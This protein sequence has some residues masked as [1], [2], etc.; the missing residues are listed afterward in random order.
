VEWRTLWLWIESGAPY[1]G[2]YAALRNEHEQ[3]LANRAVGRVFAEG[4]SV[5][6]RRCFKCHN[7]V[8]SRVGEE[9][10]LPFDYEARRKSKGVVARPTAVYERLVLEDDPVARFSA[11]VM[12]NLTRPHLSPMLLGPLAR[13]AGGFGSCGEVFRHQDDPDYQTLLAALRRAK[14][15]LDTEPRFATP[16]FQPNPQYVREMK[17]YGILAPTSDLAQ[18]P[19]DVFD[20]DQRYWR[21]LWHQ[22]M[23]TG[24]RP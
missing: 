21:S 17:K 10:R 19:L 15:D 18:Q 4:G 3:E 12:L 2:T 22:P 13:A 6:A 14:E 23:P 1:A 20:I 16:T 8:A 24:M 11:N 9:M 7:N 5:I